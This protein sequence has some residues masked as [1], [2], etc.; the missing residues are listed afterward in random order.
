MNVNQAKYIAGK[1]T[2]VDQK[3]LPHHSMKNSSGSH[4]SGQQ[5]ET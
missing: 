1:C 5:K 3:Y 4:E 2:I